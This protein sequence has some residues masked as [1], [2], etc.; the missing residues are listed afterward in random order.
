[1]VYL[2]VS[3][4]H[5]DTIVENVMSQGKPRDKDS[6]F[7][8]PDSLVFGMNKSCELLGLRNSDF[9]K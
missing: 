6:S 5:F 3:L 2:A 9:F 4:R 7:F 1:M 8:R